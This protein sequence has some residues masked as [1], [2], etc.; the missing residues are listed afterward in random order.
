MKNDSAPGLGSIEGAQ[1]A[2][3]LISKTKNR[4]SEESQDQFRVVITKEANASLEAVVKKVNTGF[5]AGAV[6][7]TDIAVYVF[8]NLPKILS[9]ADIKIIRSQH[10]DEKKVLGSLLKTSDEL[11]EDLRRALREHYGVLD[12][13]KRRTLR[14]AT[15]S[16]TENQGNDPS[17]A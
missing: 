10:F 16:P 3:G 11:P 5:E 2:R 8:L 6:S 1:A 15:C 17:A 7:R 9:D 13:E 4:S 14:V 12:K